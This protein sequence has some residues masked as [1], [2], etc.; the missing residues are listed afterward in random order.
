MLMHRTLSPAFATR[1]PLRG[2]RARTPEGWRS[3]GQTAAR[4]G[5]ARAA[6]RCLAGRANTRFP[7]G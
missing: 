6:R 1:N 7:L 5:G 3:F 2:R 4:G